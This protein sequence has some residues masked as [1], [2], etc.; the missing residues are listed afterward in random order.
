MA[1]QATSQGRHVAKVAPCSFGNS[2]RLVPP[3]GFFRNYQKMPATKGGQKSRVRSNTTKGP[4]STEGHG[5]RLATR[6]GVHPLR[7]A[8]RAPNMTIM[9]KQE[10][11]T[12]AMVT[13]VVKMTSC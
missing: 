11:E 3:H 1:T 2:K 12:A 10:R 6:L 13:Q 7:C 9:R 8:K 5:R 4:I